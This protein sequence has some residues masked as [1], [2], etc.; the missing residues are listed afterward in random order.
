M[1]KNV[2]PMQDPIN[3]LMNELGIRINELEEK[4]R[5]LKDRILLIGNNLIGTKE[6]LEKQSLESKRHFKNIEQDIKE[7][8]QLNERILNELGN[9]ARKNELEILKRQM[10]MFEPLEFARIKDIREIVKEELKNHL[11]NK[12]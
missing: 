5:I 11:V 3:G 10:K 12:D 9:F 6:E 4:Q 7:I 8:K 1:D 2:N